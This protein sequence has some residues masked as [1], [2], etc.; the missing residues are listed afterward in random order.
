MEKTVCGAETKRTGNPCQKRALANGRCK[1]H[2]G[3]STGP[4]D[5][6]KHRQALKGNKN[7][8]KTG[9]YERIVFENLSEQEKALYEQVPMEPKE[10]VNIRYKLIEIRAF[11]IMKRYSEELNKEKPNEDLL[12]SFENAL[13]RIDARAAELI[14]ENRALASETTGSDNGSLNSLVEILAN[15]RGKLISS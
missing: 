13:S 8:V 11:R 7:A 3:K 6:E 12:E 1:L 5:K 10:Q 14:R 2:G 15:A 9:E 4:K